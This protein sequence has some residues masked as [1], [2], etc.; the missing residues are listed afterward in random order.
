M[1]EREAVFVTVDWLAVHLNDP[2]LVVVDG[3]WYLPTMNRDPEREFLDGHIPGAIRFDIDA[4]R[5][6]AAPYPHMMPSEAEFARMVGALG[7]SETMTIIVYDGAGLFGA[8]RV[9]WMLRAMGAS[10]IRLLDGGLPAWKARNLPLE[11]GPSTRA[12][13]VFKAR[14]DESLV[15]KTDDVRRALET[16]S[17]QVVDA[18][19]AD[20]FR[21]DAPEPRPGVRA[22]HMPGSLN[23]PFPDT[24]ADGR[25]MSPDQIEAAFRTAGVNLSEPVITSCGSGVSAA[26][27]ALALE[28][29]GRKVEA[30]YDGS[31]AEW[32]SR[33]DCPVDTGPT[34]SMRKSSQ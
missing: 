6:L 10:N 18:R 19:P 30:L 25:L 27:L 23:L 1:L 12:A 15:A 34:R 26:I 14:F 32:G 2:G 17:A 4:I 21:G 28:M 9:R 3:S 24:I 20:R 33:T 7:L 11:S 29:T 31:W 5:D 8:P 13:A 16:G 22:G